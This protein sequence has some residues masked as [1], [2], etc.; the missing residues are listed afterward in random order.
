MLFLAV[1]A[2]R[3]RQRSTG[4]FPL[5]LALLS[6]VFDT[7]ANVFFLL[8]TPDGRA[9]RQRGVVSLYPVVVAV[10]AAIFLKE[11]LTGCSWA[12]RASR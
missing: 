5:R 1:L 11:R 6:G 7:L 10:L 3:S 8:S 9:G 4:P 2:T 12:A